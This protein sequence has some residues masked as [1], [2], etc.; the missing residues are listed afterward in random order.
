[1]SLPQ[2]PF[3]FAARLALLA[4]RFGLLA[5]QRPMVERAG[6]MRLPFKALLAP[7]DSIWWQDGPPLERLVD[8][9]RGALSGPVQEVKARAHQLLVRCVELHSQ[10]LDA[11]DLRELDGVCAPRGEQA[12][13][14][15]LED[16]AA[17]PAGRAVRIISYKD[18]V[19]AI[20]L[21]LPRYLTGQQIEVRQADWHGNRLYWG[22][23]QQAAAFCVALVYAR[24]RGLQVI[25]PALRQ[26]YR[27]NVAGLA[28]LDGAFHVLA[29]PEEA[30]S[31]PQFMNL[32]LSNG[33][34]YARIDQISPPGT[35][36]WLLLPRADAAADALGSALRQAGAA[37]IP[38]Y[39]GSLRH[40]RS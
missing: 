9:P 25:L 24:R 10:V 29:L 40:Q 26:Q 27:L 34:P 38:G 22:G 20:S 8:L 4:Q 1:M 7:Q 6:L 2:P 5:R 30:W 36:E 28:A 37:D 31:Q 39:L 23:S 3:S 18:F 11:F 32:L 17:T 14:L 21:A 35:P 12:A 15:H 19:K 33:T 16:F 13:H